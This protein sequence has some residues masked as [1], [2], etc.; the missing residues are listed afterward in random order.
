MR[1]S[2]LGTLRDFVPIR[3]L[4]DLEAFRIAEL[5]AQRFLE[6]VHVKAP[7]VPEYA[8]AD[9]PRVHVVRR[10]PWPASGATDWVNGRWVIVLRGSEPLTRQRFSL[11]HE[12]KHIVDDRFAHVLY[13][14]IPLD[15]RHDFIEAVC[16]HFAASLLMPRDWL[17]AGWAGG[18]RS[19]RTL[20]DQFQVSH[21]AMEMRLT[22]VGLLPP[23]GR[24]GHARPKAFAALSQ[25][26][27]LQFG[28][29]IHR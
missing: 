13:Q 12:F 27:Q 24:C 19:I 1:S 26:L 14:A 15:R 17:E 18:R 2:V 8:I 5:Q 6:L 7:P 28:P 11:G 9:L 21:Q 10:S 4:S 3:P 25:R 22:S 16:D 23:R 29:H 20:A